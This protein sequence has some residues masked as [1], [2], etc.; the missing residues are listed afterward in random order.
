LQLMNEKLLEAFN[1]VGRRF[2]SYR[3]NHLSLNYAYK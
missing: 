2:V 1:T 3:H